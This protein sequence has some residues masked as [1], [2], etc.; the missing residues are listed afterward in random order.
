MINHYYGLDI[1]GNP[2]YVN[3]YYSMNMCACICEVVGNLQY[4][5][6]LIPVPVYAWGFE[7]M[8]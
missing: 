5:H 6:S 7:Y 8:E 3:K 1:L 4:Q 2:S